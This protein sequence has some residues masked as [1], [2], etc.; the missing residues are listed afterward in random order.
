MADWPTDQAQQLLVARNSEGIPHNS[1]YFDPGYYQD[2]GYQGVLLDRSEARAES[3]SGL[4]IVR[5]ANNGTDGMI[6]VHEERSR[7]VNQRDA[8]TQTGFGGD[9]KKFWAN[10]KVD[11]ALIPC[12]WVSCSL[13][14][15]FLELPGSTD[16]CINILIVVSQVVFGTWPNSLPEFSSSHTVIRGCVTSATALALQSVN[17]KVLLNFPLGSYLGVAVLI[18]GMFYIILGLPKLKTLFCKR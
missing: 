9:E 15:T 16:N 11:L 7:A 14:G 2:C 13:C 10:R 6:P 18:K 8:A 12:M 3:A 5:D 4:E 1:G 17:Y